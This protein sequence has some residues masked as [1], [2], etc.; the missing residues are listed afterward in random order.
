MSV[1]KIYQYPS[2]HLREVCEPVVDFNA[3]FQKQIDD[4]IATMY[5]ASGSVGLAAPQVGF[6]IRVFVIDVAAKT[7]RDQLKV[8]I[9]PRIIQQSRNKQ[10]REGCLSFPEYLANVKRATRVTVEAQNREGEPVI[11]EV[12]DLEAIAVQHELDHLDGVLMIDRI[13]SLKTDWI[14]RQ[15]RPAEE[16]APTEPAPTE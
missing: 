2:P 13:N 5:G 9:N 3:G 15:P 11:Y 10:V 1:L 14:R 12:R 16:P 8:L 4:L 6:P 7:T